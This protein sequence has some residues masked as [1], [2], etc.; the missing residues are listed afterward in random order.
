MS[1][2]LLEIARL[3]EKTYGKGSFKDLGTVPLNEFIEKYT[4]Q[5]S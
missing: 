5:V 4:K 3:V 1:G 2:R